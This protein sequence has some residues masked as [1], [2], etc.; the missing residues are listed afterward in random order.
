MTGEML[1]LL[2]VG[3]LVTAISILSCVVYLYYFRLWFRTHIAQCSLGLFTI[4]G[5][6][7]RKVNPQVIVNSYI[8]L[9]KAGIPVEVELLEAH[10][11][12]GG[13]SRRVAQALVA[14]SK[15]GNETAFDDACSIDL[16]GGDV[17]KE[18]GTM[19]DFASAA[20]KL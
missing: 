1:L 8:D 2:F 9:Y 12:A 10:T 13:N 5:M 4:I 7:F 18:I 3:L 11:R 19:V 6:T 15:N 16:A 20:S 17:M 14:A